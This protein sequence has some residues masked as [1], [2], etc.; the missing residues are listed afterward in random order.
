MSRRLMGKRLKFKLVLA[1][2]F[3]IIIAG[4]AFLLLQVIGES[5]LDDHL[6]KSDFIENRQRD[7]LQKF[8]DF[9]EDAQVSTL[10]RERLSSWIREERYLNLYIFKDQ[11]LVFSSNASYVLSEPF[12]APFIPSGVP[13]TTIVFADGD[14]QIY[15]VGFYEYQYYTILL[16]FTVSIAFILFVVSFLLMINKKTSYIGA[17]EQ[18]IKILEGGNLNYPI[19][20]AGNDELS[21]LAQSIDEMRKSFIERLDSEEQVRQANRKLITAMSHDL[22]TPLT[23]L[24][25]Y[26]DIIGLNKYK[27]QEDLLRYIHNSREKAY[28]IKA[29]SDKL[30]QYFTVPSPSEEEEMELETYEGSALMDQLIEEQLFVLNNKNYPFVTDTN[31]EHFLLE[32]NLVG[33]RRVFDNIFSNIQKYGD[34]RHPAHIHYRLK[35]PFVQLTVENKIKH[36]DKKKDSNG[37][38]LSSCKSILQKHGGKLTVWQDQ[39]SFTLQ[40]SLPASIGGD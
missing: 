19:T 39:D 26:M 15:L 9:V 29:L 12:L 18:E 20:V 6:S 32:V 28:Q 37:I 40:I 17:L 21:S 11:A 13:T 36:S 23:I 24:L 16:I 34:P 27:T 1:V 30:F 4:A 22:R 31:Y 25:G 5:V 35:G 14:A 3:S 8:K 33:I 7:A 2:L 10:D 38:G